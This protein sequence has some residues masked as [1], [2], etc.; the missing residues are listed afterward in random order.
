MMKVGQS[1]VLERRFTRGDL[2]EYADLAGHAAGD[3]VLMELARRIEGEV[4]QSD[5]AARY[6]GEE[7][8]VLLPGTDTES[9]MHLA[10]RI[11]SAVASDPVELAGGEFVPVTASIA[12][13]SA[14]SGRT[15]MPNSGVVGCICI[16]NA[17]SFTPCSRHSTHHHEKNAPPNA[18]AQIHPW[19]P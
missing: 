2:D 16:G 19:P 13:N 14:F 9:A 15:R 4:R 8:V 18:L 7:F 12:P 5:V 1:A 17:S 10:E 3:T 6:G 11:R